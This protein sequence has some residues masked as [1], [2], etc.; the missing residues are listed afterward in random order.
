[1]SIDCRWQRGGNASNNCT[2]LAQLGSDCEFFGSVSNTVFWQFIKK[3]FEK[4][5]ID[6]QHCIMHENKEFPLSTV[7]INLKNGSRTI[8][9]SN[10]QWPEI[11]FEDFIK[12]NMSDYSWI[13][14]EGRNI[15]ELLKMMVYVSDYNS[16]GCLSPVKVSLEIEKPNSDLL[17]L[18]PLADVVFIGKDFAVHYGWVNMEDAVDVMKF[19][20][21]SRCAIN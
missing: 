15:D 4:Y 14:F 11:T 3:D 16:N 21:K 17:N 13:H 10:K 6:I 2:V 20:I 5:S 9:H 19:Y 7:I 18:A 12:L 8:V 1:R